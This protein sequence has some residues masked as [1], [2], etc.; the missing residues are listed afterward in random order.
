MTRV[1]KILTA[2]EA[3]DGLEAVCA[4]TLRNL[5]ATRRDW[6]IV[7]QTAV[8]QLDHVDD[9]RRTQL[10][11]DALFVEVAHLKKGMLRRCA[12]EFISWRLNKRMRPT[13][14]EKEI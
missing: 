8:F 7:L 3:A 14:I 2:M 1:L 4:A 11:Q 13:W 6:M 12:D 10:I 5:P 9:E